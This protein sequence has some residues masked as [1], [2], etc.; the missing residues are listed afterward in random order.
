MPTHRMLAKA[1]TLSAALILV[2]TLG[3]AHVPN[4][5]RESGPS[6][7]MQWESP[8]ATDVKARFKPAEPRGRDWTTATVCTQSGVVSHWPLYFEDPFEDKGHGRTDATDPHNVYHLGWEDWVAVPY[9]IS[10][11]TLNW[12][13]LP[14]SA[15]VTPPCTVMESDGV[16]S[17][18]L[19][20]YDHDATR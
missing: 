17:K 9:G 3:C 5:Y 7:T 19:V 16:I 2:S 12:L 15:V 20:W 13:M 1:T 10:R 8:T 11:F 14:V 4:H 6:T 18:Q